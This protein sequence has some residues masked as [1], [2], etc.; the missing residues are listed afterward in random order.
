MNALCQTQPVCALCT[1]PDGSIP[2]RTLIRQL[3]LRDPKER[4]FA[5]STLVTHFAEVE[6]VRA[7]AEFQ[8]TRAK[9][10]ALA[11]AAFSFSSGFV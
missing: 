10:V 4:P 7:L 1:P 8:H 6:N 11:G 2:F 9:F 5:Q 3:L